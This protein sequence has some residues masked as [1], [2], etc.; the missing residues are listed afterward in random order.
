MTDNLKYLENLNLLIFFEHSFVSL[1]FKVWSKK[2]NHSG[3]CS[4]WR[5]KR[6]QF[7]LVT[8][9]LWKTTFGA[10]TSKVD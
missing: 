7:L 6:S 8:E 10:L 1:T 9:M 4:F 3:F 2:R 5:N